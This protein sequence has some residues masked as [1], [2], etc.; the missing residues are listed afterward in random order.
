MTADEA[1]AAVRGRRARGGCCSRI[2]PRELPLDELV[3]DGF[4]LEP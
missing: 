1:R 3:Y 2:A 4:E